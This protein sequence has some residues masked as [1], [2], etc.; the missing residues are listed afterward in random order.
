M[1]RIFLLTA[2]VG[3]LLTAQTFAQDTPEPTPKPTPT[4][5]APAPTPA[6]TPTP[7]A[8]APPA[9][10]PAPPAVDATIPAPAPAEK[11]KL[12]PREQIDA[13]YK[14]FADERAQP[15][16][17][18]ARQ[19]LLNLLTSNPNLT[20]QGIEQIAVAIQRPLGTVGDYID[21]EIQSE[22]DVTK[23]TQIVK[24]IA[25]FSNQPFMNEFTFYKTE[26]GYWRLVNLRYDANLATMFFE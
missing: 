1:K 15:G 7:P 17:G 10:K 12:S 16:T 11:P 21:H 23:R 24:V 18:K 2:L 22:K 6:P 5:P 20:P 9:A 14:S 13:F 3:A 25:H 26:D 8:P 19:G 4:P